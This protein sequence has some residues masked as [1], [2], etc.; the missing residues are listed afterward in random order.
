M[1]TRKI[2]IAL[3]ALG[4]TLSMPI[5]Q[6]APNTE[7]E[8]AAQAA[9]S[10]GNHHLV[11]TMEGLFGGI[12]GRAHDLTESVREQLKE[13]FYIQS[14][15]H[16]TGPK[17][18]AECAKIWKKVHGDALRLTVVG[19]SLGGGV[20][21][22]DLAKNLKNMTIN[23]MLILDGRHGSELTCGESSKSSQYRKPDNVERATAVYQCGF[24]AGR[25]FVKE[26]GVRNR[27][28]AAR[29]FAHLNLPSSPEAEEELL[30]LLTPSTTAAT[31]K[32]TIPSTADKGI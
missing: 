10:K 1:K 20:A 21:A 6:A 28:S 13:D 26:E 24:M 29:P 25:T 22:M 12:E 3:I 8:K 16:S 5:A 32:V 4:A 23:E 17:Q 19:H 31:G 30:R 2:T 27:R 14:Y 18:G 15:S 7:C 11:I 9:L